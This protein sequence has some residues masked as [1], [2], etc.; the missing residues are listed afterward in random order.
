LGEFLEMP[1]SY[2]LPAISKVVLKVY[3]ILGNEVALLVNEVKTQ[4]VY[5]VE[6]N[7]KNLASGIYFYRLQVGDFSSVKKLIIMK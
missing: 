7:A 3:D 6:F 2:Q 4:G 1:I 5:N